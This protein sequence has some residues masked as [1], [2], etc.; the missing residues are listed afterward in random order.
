MTTRRWHPE[1]IM[2][3]DLRW[4]TPNWSSHSRDLQGCP[5]Q[6]C[7]CYGAGSCWNVPSRT[8][9]I[10]YTG[11]ASSK[12]QA[13]DISEMKQPAT[14]S[15]TKRIAQV[16]QSSISSY[17]AGFCKDSTGCSDVRRFEWLAE[18]ANRF[19]KDVESGCS[20][21]RCMFSNPLVRK[22][23]QGKNLQYNKVQE[24]ILRRV[25]IWPMR[26]E[27][28]GVEAALEFLYEDCKMPT[29]SFALA[30]MLRLS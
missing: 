22:L 2:L 15:F 29:R 5:S 9:N 20:P 16:T 10:C 18:C 3:R 1:D 11:A 8:A 6:M 28:R 23:L 26:V 12:Q 17:F 4:R 24:S 21:Q 27:G 19:L 13:T 14:N 7:P 25:H 30:L